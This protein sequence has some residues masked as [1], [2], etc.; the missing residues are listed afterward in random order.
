MFGKLGSTAIEP[1]LTRLIY[2][3]KPP[4]KRNGELLDY[5]LRPKQFYESVFVFANE[6]VK[7][8]SENLSKGSKQYAKRYDEPE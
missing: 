8:K 3:F 5:N 1:T 4:P 7:I 2:G 6:K